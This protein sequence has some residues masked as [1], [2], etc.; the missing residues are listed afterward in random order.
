[1]YYAAIG[2]IGGLS[3]VLGGRVLD[4]TQH[5]SG[6]F[7]IFT[8]DSYFPL[9]G[10][11][12]A[13]TILS[14]ILF[15]RVG[16]DSPIGV[17]QFAGMFMHGNPVLALESMFRY[18]RARDE[19]QTVMMTERMGQT[20]SPLTVDELLEALKDPRFNVR[21]EAIISIA[22][23]ESDPRLVEALCQIVEGTEVSLSVIA[24]WALG[25]M[26]DERAIAALRHGLDSQY[27]SIKAHCARALGTLGDHALAPGLLANLQ[28]ETDKGLRMAYAAALGNLQ[29]TEAMSALFDLLYHTDN[30]GARLELAL[31][32]ARI[33]GHEH[34]LIRLLRQTRQDDATAIAQAITALKRRLDLDDPELDRSMAGCADTFAR[35]DLAGGVALLVRLMSLLPPEAYSPS[36]RAML[37]ECAARLEAFKATRIE[38]ILLALH[39]LEVA[40]E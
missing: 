34:H 10:F 11:G 5:V 35:G 30:E 40:T 36:Q 27:R 29:Y 38:Y 14:V 22:R 13:L 17:R 3:Q 16:A 18:Y 2:L 8:V 31:D 19:R 32:L 37:D 7:L 4:F 39:T 24:A 1:V 12:L 25:R 9:F 20:K 23:M 28:A 33:V 21:F 6:Q 26:G 15:R